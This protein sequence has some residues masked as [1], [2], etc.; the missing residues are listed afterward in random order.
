MKQ[1]TVNQVVVPLV[2]GTKKIWLCDQ[3][4]IPVASDNPKYPPRHPSPRLNSIETCAANDVTGCGRTRRT[5]KYGHESPKNIHAVQRLF[6][7]NVSI[8][9]PR[10][11]VNR[12]QGKQK[13]LP[14]N[15]CVMGACVS[16][17]VVSDKDHTSTL[18]LKPYSDLKGSHGEKRNFARPNSSRSEQFEGIL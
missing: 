12:Q 10:E 15:R 8:I 18:L 14:K 9:N 16:F 11:R 4:E 2:W 1:R 3:T 13:I 6:S 5:N 7:R 17:L